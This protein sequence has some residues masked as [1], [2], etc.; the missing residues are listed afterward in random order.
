MAARSGNTALAQIEKAIFVDPSG[1]G[2]HN[3]FVSGSVGAAARLLNEASSVLLATGFYIPRVG[4]GENDGPL[5]TA[6]LARALLGAGKRVV[7]V[8]DAENVALVNAALEGYGATAAAVA[9]QPHERESA[10]AFGAKLAAEHAPNVGVAI[11]RPGR[12][13]DGTYRNMRGDRICS[14]TAPVD[15]LF[16]PGGVPGMYATVGVGDGGNEIGMGAPNIRT[17]V[18]VDV[19][20]GAA[21]ATVVPADVTIATGVS[22]WGGAALAAAMALAVRDP[23]LAAPHALDDAAM[24]GVLAAGG[25]DGVLGEGV[26]SV[27]GLAWDEHHKPMLERLES[28]VRAAV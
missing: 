3:C 23:E 16:L 9:V 2:I 11:E 28:I 15:A 5:G 13:A 1:R 12:A 25:V 14:S 24:R 26:M 4:A 20:D 22:N 21:L 27:D 18:L 17:A 8:T 6:A 10:D 19:P 7:V